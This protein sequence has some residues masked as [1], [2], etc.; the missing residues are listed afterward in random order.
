MRFAFVA[1]KDLVRIEIGVINEAHGGSGGS[2]VVLT[3][4]RERGGGGQRILRSASVE[5]LDYAT[6]RPLTGPSPS[7]GRFPSSPDF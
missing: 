7:G 2:V 5:A 4:M 6:N 1:A 3:G